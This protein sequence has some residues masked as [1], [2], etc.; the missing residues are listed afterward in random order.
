M[1][2]DKD[3]LSLS[4]Y[5]A[6]TIAAGIAT[7]AC[8]RWTRPARPSS[9]GTSSCCWPVP[10]SSAKRA[11]PGRGRQRRGDDL[12][13]VRLRFAPHRGRGGRG[14]DAGGG[15]T[16]GRRAHE[17]ENGSGPV[18]RRPARTVLDDGRH[19]GDD[20]RG[21]SRNVR[22]LTATAD[23]H[24]GRHDRVLR[25]QLHAGADRRG[26]RAGL[27][28]RLSPEA[29]LPVPGLAGGDAD[30]ARTARRGRD[31]DRSYARATPHPSDRGD[32]SRRP[33]GD[34]DGAPGHARL[35]LGPPHP[36]ALRGRHHAGD[37]G[38]QEDPRVRSS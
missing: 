17:E 22:L 16:A 9:P 19:R 29:R 28:H 10:C 1:T 30:G 11:A 25:G 2:A 24:A 38:R 34:G 21:G 8:S 23:R 6:A 20:L 31:P 26:A 27:Q 18:Q 5:L 4:I 14:H 15:L 7:V 32:P 36:A 35:P 12:H 13:H 3:P 33:A 37:P